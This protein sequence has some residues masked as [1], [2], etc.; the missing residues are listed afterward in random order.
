M[1]ISLRQT[2]LKIQHGIHLTPVELGDIKHYISQLRSS[3]Q[4]SSYDVFRQRYAARLWFDYGIILSAE[5]KTLD[6]EEKPVGLPAH[7]TEEVVIKY[8]DANAS[9][10]PGLQAHFERLA[11]YPYVT[12]IQSYRYFRGKKARQDRFDVAG[13]DCLRGIFTNKDR[14]ILYHVYLSENHLQKARAACRQL[15]KDF[16][17]WDMEEHEFGRMD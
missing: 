10:E 5:E 3:A 14:S 8:E 6:I 4:R 12:R 16:Y 13:E 9:K 2:L 15:N 1:K 17:G 11:R 7:R